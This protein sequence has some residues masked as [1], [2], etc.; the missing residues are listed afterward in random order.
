MDG[1]EPVTDG[2]MQ[3]DLPQQQQLAVVK[4]RTQKKSR[5]STDHVIGRARTKGIYRGGAFPDTVLHDIIASM[6]S[7]G[8]SDEFAGE[9]GK[10]SEKTRR[11]GK[12]AEQAMRCVMDMYIKTVVDQAVLIMDRNLQ[13]LTPENI[14]TAIRILANE[15]FFGNVADQMAKSK[16]PSAFVMISRRGKP[17]TID[18][19]ERYLR[20]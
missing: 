16:D 2:D 12:G 9:E 6:G 10:D 18:K 13:K 14:D 11:V 17:P 5:L 8:W 1:G 4:R 7:T 20:A 3:V 19:I 15:H